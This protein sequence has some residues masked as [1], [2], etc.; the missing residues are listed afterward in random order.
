V[1]PGLPEEPLTRVT[2]LVMVG[3]LK[4]FNESSSGTKGRLVTRPHS[5]VAVIGAGMAGRA[6]VAGYR[7][8]P[9][10]FASHLHDVRLIADANGDV[11]SVVLEQVAGISTVPTVALSEDGLRAVRLLRGVVEAVKGGG[12]DVPGG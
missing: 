12:A 7:S 8:L 11:V 6:H 1:G 4:R 10:V 9:T 5:G 3:N 2:P